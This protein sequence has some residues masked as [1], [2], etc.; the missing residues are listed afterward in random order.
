M[1]I[2][3]LLPSAT[4]IIC[5]LGLEQQLVGVTH[6]CDYPISVQG[7]PKVTH[8]LIPVDASSKEIDMLVRERLKNERALYTLNLPVLE[9]LKPDLIVT[10]SLCDVCAV[11][12]DE[13]Q[14]A[15]CML[16]NS[17]QVVNL[18]PQTLSEVFT[19]IAQ[20]ADVTGIRNIG[21]EVNARLR[22]RVDAIIR[23]TASLQSR[24]RTALLEWLDPPFSCGHW[25]PE[26]VRLAG[27]VEGLGLEGQPSRTLSWDETL[28]WQP[29]VVLIACCGFTLERTMQDLPLLQTVP[30]W[31]E[32]PAV[33]SGRVY[34]TDG[35]HFFSRPGPRLVDSLEIMAHALHPQAHPLPGELSGALKTIY[36]QPNAIL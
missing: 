33:R 13:V 28:A 4:E 20:V 36:D 12:E 18:E 2:V 14:A 5:A 10:Q 3:S 8:T 30:G 31:Q 17:P 27:G 23:R 34:V 1:R 15:A 32:L 11:A 25:N 26:L 35:S 6:E 19:A 21:E 29:E 16:P 24:P 9:A 22:A 7:L